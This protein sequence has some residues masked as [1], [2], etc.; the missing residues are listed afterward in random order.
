MRMAPYN[1]TQLG[2][3]NEEIRLLYLTPVARDDDISIRIFHVPL[4]IPP[5]E[6]GEIKRLSLEQLQRTLPSGMASLAVTLRQLRYT[7]K[8]RIL[9]VDSICVNQNDVPERSHEIGRMR[10]I[11]SFADRTII[12]LGE[13]SDDSVSSLATIESFAEQVEYIGGGELH[14]SIEPS[15]W[16]G[17]T[18]TFICHMTLKHG[19]HVPRDKIYRVLGLVL[20]SIAGDITCNYYI[21]VAKVY[22]SAVLSHVTVTKRLHLLQHFQLIQRFQDGPSWVP[23]W[24]FEDK[25]IMICIVLG[26]HSAC[27]YSAVTLYQAP[28]TL[29]VTGIFSTRVTSVKTKCSGDAREIFQAIHR[30]EPEGLNSREYITGSSLIDAFIET[31][32]QGR[33]KE[34]YPGLRIPPS[35][36]LRGSYLKA[37]DKDTKSQNA[38]LSYVYGLSF[39]PTA[40]ITTEEVYLGIGSLGV[41]EGKLCSTST[42]PPNKS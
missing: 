18:Q 4:V 10:N 21:P 12:W 5:T 22:K 38:I 24:S 35:W 17:D 2:R 26:S 40:F 19:H 16:N 39:D 13:K 30:W 32:Y 34:R 9:W 36:E 15:Y 33:T 14:T 23:I 41:E 28:N 25:S 27:S 3:E 29:E 1:Y 37:V 11:F 7:V 6:T 20:T 42:T 8:Q 31:I